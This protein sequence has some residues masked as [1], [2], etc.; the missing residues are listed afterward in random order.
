M[1]T[2]QPSDRWQLRA[3]D[4]EIGKVKNT[5]GL[6]GAARTSRQPS[7][8]S[9]SQLG[10]LGATYTQAAAMASLLSTNAPPFSQPR[11]YSNSTTRQ[12][13]AS[14]WR[15]DD[16]SRANRSLGVFGVVGGQVVTPTP[17]SWQQLGLA[18]GPGGKPL[19]S[20]ESMGI[21]ASNE[22]LRRRVSD[23]SRICVYFKII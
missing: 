12:S 21:S 17:P 22:P 6:I 23:A 4:L 2:L 9:L 18:R 10:S 8:G 15:L 5:E 11:L 13:M 14:K 16:G 3:R 7:N 1:H 19:E 20:L